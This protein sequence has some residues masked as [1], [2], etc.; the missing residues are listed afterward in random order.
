MEPQINTDSH[1]GLGIS[2]VGNTCDIFT[3]FYRYQRLSTV[4]SV[5]KYRTQS[6]SVVFHLSAVS[7]TLCDLCGYPE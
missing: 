7:A 6:L 4:F 1:L 3:Y 5:G 2:L